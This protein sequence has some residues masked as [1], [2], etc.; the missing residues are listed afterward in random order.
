MEYWNSNN[1]GKSKSEGGG[2][3][4]L[5]ILLFIVGAIGFWMWPT[6]LKPIKIPDITYLRININPDFVFGVDENGNV[7]SFSAINEDAEELY[8][9][10]MFEGKSYEEA[11]DIAI[12]HAQENN[13]LD[14]NKTYQVNITVISDTT[15]TKTKYEDK[16][17]KSLGD[18]F[19][20]NVVEPSQE[21]VSH[22][23]S[24]SKTVSTEQKNNRNEKQ[25][26][27]I[28]MQE[29]TQVYTSK[30]NST[31]A[32]NSCEYTKVA[33]SDLSSANRYDTAIDVAKRLYSKSDYLVLTSGTSIADAYPAIGLAAKYNAPILFA[34]ALNK[35]QKYVDGGN[36][37][38][39]IERLSPK[40]IFVLGEEDVVSKDY[41]DLIKGILPNVTIKR[42][43]GE[44][45]YSTSVAIAKQ[46]I[47]NTKNSSV[48]IVPSGNNQFVD[49]AMASSISAYNK[50]PILFM[51]TDKSKWIKYTTGEENIEYH[52]EHVINYLETNPY[53][54][55][56]YIVSD[57]F[58]K[59][60]IDILKK[61]NKEIVEIDDATKNPTRVDTNINLI[62]TFN[63]SFNNIVYVS[64]TVDL[65]PASLFAAANN[66]SLI[67][68]EKTIS[69]NRIENLVGDKEI[70]NI[71]FF[72]GESI[73]KY[74]ARNFIHKIKVNNMEIKNCYVVNNDSTAKEKVAQARELMF[75]TKQAVFYVPHQDD[76][77]IYYQQIIT[78]A[79]DDLGA[80]NVHVV[81]LTD[82]AGSYLIKPGNELSSMSATEFTKARDKEFNKALEQLSGNSGKLNIYYSDDAIFKEI[83]NGVRFKDSSDF[84]KYSS[85]VNK[86]NEN[87]N[88]MKG[89]M[90]YFDNKYG[91]NITHF[92]FSYSDCHT[93]HTAIGKALNDLYFDVNRDKEDY[94]TYK[95]S[96][97]Q[98]VYLIHR[99]DVKVD[100]SSSNYIYV[101]DAYRDYVNT[102]STNKRMLKALDMFKENSELGI[103]GIGYKSTCPELEATRYAINNN[104]LT[105]PIFI[106]SKPNSITPA[107]SSGCN[108]LNSNFKGGVCSKK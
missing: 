38:T 76:E 66:A 97:F 40:T 88:K 104:T 60:V 18:N 105:T 25:I 101:F 103:I 42:L 17:S 29:F 12:E 94:P 92:G 10:D 21:E 59:E 77:T 36:T 16:L 27:K 71:Y 93:D 15:E 74:S 6:Y 83:M 102:E 52:E 13:V 79:I 24:V 90:L 65:V 78:S 51:N 69:D 81:L 80:E 55:K 108:N 106:P 54:K 91:S 87:I 37:L 30:Q 58:S 43:S 3:I 67:L 50:M 44:C 45:R 75:S 72:G 95:M 33:V 107:D 47:G 20:A 34:P 26:I 49:A 73:N 35:S 64:N 46:I 85:N 39:E 86:Y 23:K 82:G 22:F 61:T 2:A 8:T 32:A 5:I 28:E 56:I 57:L 4:Y 89:I 62:N 68:V 100:L 96:Q 19:I 84:V 1:Y 31:V 70:K 53:I 63:K 98:N 41:V 9:L 7:V 48:M 14:P 99:R 11:L